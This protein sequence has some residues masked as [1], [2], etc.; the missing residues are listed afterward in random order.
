MN[1]VT[2][3]LPPDADSLQSAKEPL[4]IGAKWRKI[5]HSG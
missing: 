3:K 2:A 5:K 4:P 1:V